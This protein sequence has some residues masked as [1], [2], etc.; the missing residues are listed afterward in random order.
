MEKLDNVGREELRCLKCLVLVR[1]TSANLELLVEE[2]RAPKYSQ[3]HLY[4]TN[5]LKNAYL[6]RLAEADEQ[7]LVQSV[8]EVYA[9]YYALDKNHFSIGLAHPVV[10]EQI[11]AW[12]PKALQRSKEGLVAVLLGLR[13]FPGV[14]RYDGASLMASRLANEVKEALKKD[15]AGSF[16]DAGS[17]SK[18]VL[19]IVDR[20]SDLV[21]PLLLQWTYQAL[22]HDLFGITNGFVDTSNYLYGSE[23]SAQLLGKRNEHRH[24]FVPSQDDFYAETA[25]ANFG[26]V[27]ESLQALIRGYQERRKAMADLESLAGMKRFLEDYPK[28][29]RMQGVMAKHVAVGQAIQARVSE[30]GLLLISEA[31]QGIACE[32]PSTRALEELLAN[33]S[34]GRPFKFKLALLF[35]LR[36]SKHPF[37]KA[38]NLLAFF[39][40][41]RRHGLTD[42][43]IG[44][45]D[46]ALKYAQGDPA[47]RGSGARAADLN[48]L[49]VS[50]ITREDQNVYT[51]HVP[52]LISAVDSLTKGKLPADAYPAISIAQAPS[53][54]QPAREIIV[55][56]VGGSTYEEACHLE[57]YC[58]HLGSGVSVVLGGTTVHNARSLIGELQTVRK[59]LSGPGILNR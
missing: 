37:S 39:D 59:H 38:F 1:P 51:Q 19:L 55:F 23:E 48:A 5:F 42:D 29:T 52:P 15:V 27:S 43:D 13:K 49:A 50:T 28:L 32:A 54:E 36:S 41:L 40:L 22:L 4:F 58:R 46:F 9:D 34:V 3:Y 53:M 11:N 56:V 8:A 16:G 30:D 10:G 12:S 24:V 57:R 18:A 47:G 31:E 6:E 20:K 7:Q 2:L 44:L 26:R 45:V 17:S 21:T 35:A 25:Q 33:P 14:I